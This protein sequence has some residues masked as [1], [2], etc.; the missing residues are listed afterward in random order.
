M[1]ILDVKNRAEWRNWL[2]ANHD[3]E[4]EVWLVFD[5]KKTGKQSIEY[6]A[7]LEEALC[8]GW[9]DSIIKNVDDSKYIRKFTPRKTNS[10]WSLVNKKLVD[11]LITDGL[12]TEHGL[13]K[14]EAARQSGQWEN[15][16][17][18]PQMKFEIPAEFVEALQ[19]N[20]R[21]RDFFDKLAPTY[22]MQYIRWI[23]VAKR[24]ET[25]EKRINESIQL[26]AEGKKLGL[27]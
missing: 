25:R 22:Q 23:E 9:I 5:K 8:Y 21:A 26:L 11:Q 10:K 6:E 16:T 3:K 7:S 13:K 4:T 12:M 1:K 20:K 17:T 15:P 18:K 19:K 27:K 14:V 2:A 24:P